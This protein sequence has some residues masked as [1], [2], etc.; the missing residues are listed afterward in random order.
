MCC[1]LC[2]SMEA[3]YLTHLPYDFDEEMT[4]CEVNEDDD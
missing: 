1:P 3:Y 4:N 2:T